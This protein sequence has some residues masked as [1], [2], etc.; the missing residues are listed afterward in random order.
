MINT[1]FISPCD[2]D[3]CHCKQYYEQTRSH[4]N[5]EITITNYNALDINAN[6]NIS[7]I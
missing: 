7:T 2:Y 3:W 4:H 6:N 5:E 1:P